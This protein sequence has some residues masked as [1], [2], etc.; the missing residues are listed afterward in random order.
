MWNSSR[1]KGKLEHEQRNV[2]NKEYSGSV[3]VCYV[4][5]TKMGLEISS[6]KDAFNLF[7]SLY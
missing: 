6:V 4:I 2:Y 5:F 1:P 7:C 3:D